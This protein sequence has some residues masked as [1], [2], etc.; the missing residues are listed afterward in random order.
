[1]PAYSARLGF[2]GMTGSDIRIVLRAHQVGEVNDP[3]VDH[4]EQPEDY[5]HTDGAVWTWQGR[6]R[7][8]GGVRLRMYD[9]V[10]RCGDSA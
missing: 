8:A 6:R 2:T 4:P 1:M 9:L 7:I 10:T 5:V 3:V